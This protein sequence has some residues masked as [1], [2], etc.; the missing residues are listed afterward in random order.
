MND[1]LN[2]D[3]ELLAD[4]CYRTVQSLPAGQHLLSLT[5]NAHKIINVAYVLTW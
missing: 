4:Q 3:L 2:V 5:Q 1:V